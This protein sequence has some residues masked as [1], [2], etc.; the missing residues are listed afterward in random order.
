MTCVETFIKEQVNKQLVSN[1][2]HRINKPIL[3]KYTNQIWCLDLIDV[4]TY[5][6][7]N[8]NYNYILNVIDVFSRKL[9]LEP[10][11]NKSSLL[12]KNA[13]QRVI[14]R[15]DV[16]PKYLISD[17]GTEFLKEFKIYCELKQLKIFI[18][19]HIHPL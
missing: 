8:K 12:T 4:E 5:G 2:T 11:K 18:M 16:K 7:R 19:I 15:A 10:M 3:S 17:N 9:W 1:F 6:T 13:F 14:N